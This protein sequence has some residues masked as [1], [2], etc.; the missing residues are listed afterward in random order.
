[1]FSIDVI[2]TGGA[3]KYTKNTETV[4]VYSNPYDDVDIDLYAVPDAAQHYESVSID[5]TV[6]I[7]C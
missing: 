6:I 7:I 4:E 2:T 1:M 3:A 5:N